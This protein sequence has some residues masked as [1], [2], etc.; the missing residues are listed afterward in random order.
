MCN[1]RCIVVNN[2]RASIRI[3]IEGGI[4]SRHSTGDIKC[5]L[6]GVSMTR[7]ILDELR[8][9]KKHIDGSIQI[10]IGEHFILLN[11]PRAAIE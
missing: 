11:G 9:Y 2:F 5:V 1:S 10:E 7:M 8:G 6:V 3:K 4:H